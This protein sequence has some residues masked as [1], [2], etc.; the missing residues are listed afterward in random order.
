[1]TG[2]GSKWLPFRG[3]FWNDYFWCSQ[4]NGNGQ[5]RIFDDAEFKLDFSTQV[6][7]PRKIGC[8]GFS[9]LQNFNFAL[10]II[11]LDHIKAEMEHMIFPELPHF[12][13]SKN[14]N[15]SQIL[16]SAFFSKSPFF[17]HIG[18]KVTTQKSI[19]R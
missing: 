12:K 8:I 16:T 11:S 3:S 18:M 5:G 17:R 9:M 4:T 14:W 15:G 19:N 13:L 2:N 7:W 10:S 1:M 6:T